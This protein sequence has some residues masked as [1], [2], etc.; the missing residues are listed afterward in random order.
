[1]KRQGKECDAE[2]DSLRLQ[3]AVGLGRLVQTDL[4]FAE[5]RASE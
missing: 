2:L 1:M 4:V 5:I 3:T